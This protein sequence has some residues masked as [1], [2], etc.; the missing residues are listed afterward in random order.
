MRVPRVYVNMRLESGSIV[1]LPLKQSNYLCK[2]LRMEAGRE[3]WLFNGEGGAF[4]SRIKLA[5]VKKA[6]FTVG[7]YED[8]D[9][10][11]HLISSLVLLFPKAID[12]IL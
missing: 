8:I 7:E 1:E 11:S 5:H 4:R 9:R 10:Q 12:S 3:L 6:Q 2:A